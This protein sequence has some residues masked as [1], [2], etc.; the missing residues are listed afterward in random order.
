MI[1]TIFP[2][3]MFNLLLLDMELKKNIDK[4]YMAGKSFEKLFTGL[5]LKK[6]N[7]N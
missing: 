1:K 5:I 4:I 3:T 7:K 6:I 2:F